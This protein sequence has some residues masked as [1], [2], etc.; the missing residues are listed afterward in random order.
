MFR[1]S[2]NDIV[3]G[4]GSFWI[5]V[6]I[7]CMGFFGGA[8]SHLQLDRCSKHLDHRCMRIWVAEHRIQSASEN[9][10]QTAGCLG[11]SKKSGDHHRPSYIHVL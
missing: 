8:L 1:N 3:L 7:Y 9:L 5:Y 11:V 2:A 10:L 6:L 4:F